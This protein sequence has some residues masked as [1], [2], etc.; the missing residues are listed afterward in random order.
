MKCHS[1]YEKAPIELIEK[2]GDKAGFGFI[3][4]DVI[5]ALTISV[6]ASEI[7]DKIRD[8]CIYINLIVLVCFVI[9]I[10]IINLFF[11]NIVIIPLQRLS[12]L[13]NDISTGKANQ[14]VEA[15]GIAEISNIAKGVERMRNSVN[16][17]ISKIKKE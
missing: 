9:L 5:G 1:V 2:Y 3:V 6:P 8:V 4:G 15:G 13:V 11:Q 7:F 10:I 16:L 14:R 12:E 17:A